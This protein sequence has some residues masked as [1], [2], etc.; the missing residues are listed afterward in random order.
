MPKE[1]NPY[2]LECSFC[3]RI[4]DDGEPYLPF[5]TEDICSECF[6]ELIPKIYGMAGFGDGGF[7]HLLFEACLLSKHNRKKRFPI[8]QYKTI[9]KT[10]L[11]K[12]K[13]QC[14]H[15]GSQKA[16]TIDH[17]KPVSKGGADD[18]SNL[19]ILCKSCNSKKGAKWNEKAKERNSQ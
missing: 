2:P 13:F 8:L 1:D 12:Y 17:K 9:L 14:V 6:I 15:C 16:L 19:Q 3:H 4:I 18:I 10:L 7:I 5:H 11:H